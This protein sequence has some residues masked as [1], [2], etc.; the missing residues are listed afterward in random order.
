MVHERIPM[1]VRLLT[2]LLALVATGTAGSGGIKSCDY[3]QEMFRSGTQV[4]FLITIGALVVITFTVRVLI[5]DVRKLRLPKAQAF[6]IFDSVWLMFTFGS[7][8]A[9]AAAPVGTSV[10]S[11]VDEDIK[12]LLQEVCEFQCTNIVAAIATMFLAS[13]C[14]VFDILFTTGSIPVGSSDPPAEDF[15]FGET[16]GTP[17]S[18]KAAANRGAAE[19]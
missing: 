18:Q 14:I 2:I 6:V 11:G 19:I 15:T 13:V 7:A 1:V 5:F 3:G 16:V 4:Y 17:R 10:C 12:I 8:V 9:V